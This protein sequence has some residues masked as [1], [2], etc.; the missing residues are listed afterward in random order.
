M[1]E[2]EAGEGKGQNSGLVDM[3]HSPKGTMRMGFMHLPL[4][5]WPHSSCLKSAALPVSLAV[6]PHLG[7]TQ[8]GKTLVMWLIN[9]KKFPL[10]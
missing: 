1:R 2:H 4:A 5:V 10:R 9:S 3:P 7:A 8:Q 6:A